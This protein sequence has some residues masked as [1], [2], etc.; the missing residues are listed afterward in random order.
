[1][2]EERGK[3][4]EE[5]GKRREERKEERKGKRKGKERRK[6]RKREK[7]NRDMRDLQGPFAFCLL[8]PF[9]FCPILP[10]AFF[11]LLA[12]NYQINAKLYV[13][14]FWVVFFASKLF[15]SRTFLAITMLTT[16]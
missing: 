2:K 15:D 10:F 6:E 1:M 11:L 12:L 8:P 7:G 4:K 14:S 5:R 13:S 16:N 9:A 3:R